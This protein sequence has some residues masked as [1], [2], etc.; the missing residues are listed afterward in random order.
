VNIEIKPISKLELNNL[1]PPKKQKR[2]QKHNKFG[3]SDQKNN[4][5]IIG[6]KN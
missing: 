1:P 6:L 4:M 2:V 5:T 3:G